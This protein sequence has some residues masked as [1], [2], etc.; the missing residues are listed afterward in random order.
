MAAEHLEVYQ[1]LACKHKWCTDSGDSVYEL[2]C[3]HL[4]RLYTTMAKKVGLA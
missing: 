1:R 3:E 4:R 2:S